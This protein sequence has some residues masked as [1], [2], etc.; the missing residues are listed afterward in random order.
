MYCKYCGHEMAD[1]ALFCAKCGTAKTI[2]ANEPVTPKCTLCGKELA[3]DEYFCPACGTPAPGA[4]GSV[5]L[6]YE[7]KSKLAAGLLGILI[8]AFGIHNFYLGYTSKAI[9]QLLIAVLSCGILSPVSAIWGLI[10]GIQIL[11]GSI[12][13]DANNVPLSE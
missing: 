2:P 11:T 9:A 12:K 10:E 13:T 8:G 4:P 6:G 3:N 7:Q 5:P 1:D